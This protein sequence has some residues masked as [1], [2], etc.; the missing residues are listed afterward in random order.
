MAS[1]ATSNEHKPT[2]M[3]GPYG[4]CSLG[5]DDTFSDSGTELEDIPEKLI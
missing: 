1:D 2:Q 3:K 4:N 5:E